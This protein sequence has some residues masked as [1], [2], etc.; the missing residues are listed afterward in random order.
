MEDEHVKGKD[1]KRQCEE[2]REGGEYQEGTVTEAETDSP[3]MKFPA[4]REGLKRF[5]HAR[6]PDV[7]WTAKLGK[8]AG[9]VKGVGRPGSTV[10]QVCRRFAAVGAPTY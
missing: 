3:D 1:I 7:Y 9:Q 10:C 6:L 5:K 4:F 2:K 8:F